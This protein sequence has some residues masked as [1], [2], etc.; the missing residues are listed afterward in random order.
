M[1]IEFEA[2]VREFKS[3]ALVS[4]DKGYE[5]KLQG[6]RGMSELVHAPADANVKVVIMWGGD[7]A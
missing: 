3:K 4:L 5:V 6:D 2:M 1:K 7:V